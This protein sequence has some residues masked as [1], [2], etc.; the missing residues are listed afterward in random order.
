M[1]GSVRLRTSTVK[2]YFSTGVLVLYGCIP[3]TRDFCLQF[4]TFSKIHLLSILLIKERLMKKMNYWIYICIDY[5]THCI[6]MY[7]ANEISVFRR[8]IL[9]KQLSYYTFQII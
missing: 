2:G 5:H 6:I 9:L 7:K 3:T 8:S 4:Y 1:P